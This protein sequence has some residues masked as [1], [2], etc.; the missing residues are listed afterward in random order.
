MISTITRD[1][2][3][4]AQ[5]ALVSG[6]LPSFILS[7]FIFE[8]ASMPG[9]IRGITSLIPAKYFVSC[10]QSVFL[11]GDV[12]P[13]FLKSMAA[14]ALIGVFLLLITFKKTVKKVA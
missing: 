11:A 3:L 8:I 7:G 2:Y 12:W 6:F 4:A 10:L 1:Q 14:M 13:L 5:V 9:P